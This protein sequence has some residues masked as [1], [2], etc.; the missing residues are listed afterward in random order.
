LVYVSNLD[1]GGAHARDTIS[2]ISGTGNVANVSVGESPYG[3]V[4]DPANHEVYVADSA[5]YAQTSKGY[6]NAGVS[7]L[8]GTTLV[9]TLLRGTPVCF[10]VYD[11]SDKL[12]YVADEGAVYAIDNENS[13]IGT[14]NFTPNCVQPVYDPSNHEV[15]V[16]Q[17]DPNS[18]DTSIVA[19][20]GTSIVANISGVAARADWGQTLAY[21]PANKC[22]YA[23]YGEGINIINGTTNSLVGSGIAIS[24]PIGIAYDP[25]NGNMY[26]TGNDNVSVI[27]SSTNQIIATVNVGPYSQYFAYDS[28]NKDM[29]VTTASGIS[30]ISP[31]NALVKTIADSSQ[32][33]G[34]VY[35]PSNSLVYVANFDDGVDTVLV[36]SS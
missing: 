25:A 31:S 23:S 21:D 36:L 8:K 16:A 17:V 29:Y 13:I 35:D 27:S 10:L 14:M 6:N 9:K 2:V 5:F 20:R 28:F 30:I 19:I 12:V 26:A 32:P 33:A 1:D 4:Y 15:Y 22:I 34:L 3:M 18:I 7:V 24:G 11:P